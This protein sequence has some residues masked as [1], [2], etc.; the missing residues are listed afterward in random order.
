MKYY[1]SNQLLI[2][3]FGEINNNLNNLFKINKIL[4]NIIEETLSSNYEMASN[5]YYNNNTNI[6]PF[7]ITFGERKVVKV[8]N[9]R[10]VNLMKTFGRN[11]LT[12]FN[13][14][15]LSNLENI[16]EEE[17]GKKSIQNNINNTIE[18]NTTEENN[19][20]NKNLAL[21]IENIQNQIL[22]LKEH[23]IFNLN[24]YENQ[25]KYLDDLNKDFK[26][27]IKFTKDYFDD[28]INK[29]KIK[30]SND[31]KKKKRFK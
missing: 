14:Q 29:I 16:N 27:N 18:N 28:L 5:N 10:N 19:L 23:L 30:N 3:N 11:S 20:I 26:N 9:K 4:I 15:N 6:N 8:I 17:N 22:R 2:Q 31:D 21:K 7:K 13:N 24:L 25:K 1:F 12:F